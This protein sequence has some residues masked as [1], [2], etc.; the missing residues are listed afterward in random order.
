MSPDGL[1]HLNASHHCKSDEHDL[2]PLRPIEGFRSENP[3]EG[4]NIN[5]GELGKKGSHHT[6]EEKR[7][8]ERVYPENRLKLGARIPCLKELEQD[9]R[10]DGDGSCPFDRSPVFKG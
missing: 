3:L 8:A 2:D 6:V 10:G 5:H 7:V 9:H 4:R 1:I